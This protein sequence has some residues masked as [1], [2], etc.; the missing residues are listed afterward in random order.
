MERK[1]GLRDSMRGELILL[2]KGGR[3]VPLDVFM[4]GGWLLISFL[5]FLVVVTFLALQ[6][7]CFALGCVL[8]FMSIVA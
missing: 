7:H 8:C 2:V 6:L 5:V 1:D 4:M 3:R